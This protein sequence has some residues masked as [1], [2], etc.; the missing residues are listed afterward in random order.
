MSEEI[1]SVGASLKVAREAQGLS[2]DQAAGRLRLMVRQL[3]AMEADD[4]A[5]LGQPVFARGFV[6]NY[7]RMLGLDAEALVSRLANTD[8]EELPAIEPVPMEQPRSLLTTPWVL[9]AMA[10]LVMLI[11]IP[12]ALYLWLNSGEEPARVSVTPIRPITQ[13]IGPAAAPAPDATQPIQ[14]EPPV[15]AAVPDQAPVAASPASTPA[16]VP[17]QTPPPTPPDLADQ[18]DAAAPVAQG[19]IKLDFD[20]DA[21]VEIN[22]E[23]GRVLLHKLNPA[24]SSVTVTGTPPFTFVI[25]NAAQVRMTYNGRPLDLTPYIDIKVARFNLEQ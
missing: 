16:P 4:F 7:A 23:N 15:P 14:P 1:P 12:V 8:Q 24:G 21:W 22:E 20:A 2:L 25:G 17:A 5:A 13:P 18:T 11:A 6:R 10:A 9:G 3:S 19:T